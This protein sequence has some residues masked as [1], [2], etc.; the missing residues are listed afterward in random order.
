MKKKSILTIMKHSQAVTKITN[1]EKGVLLLHGF[2][3]SPFEMKHLGE[4]ISEQGYSIFI[5]RLPGHG[6]NIED[7]TLFNGRDWLNAAREALIEL[8]SHCREVCVI[9]LSMGGILSILLARTYPVKKIVLLSVPRAIKEKT[10]YLAPVIGLFKKILRREDTT[11]GLASE[12]ARRVHECY[13]SGIPLR[14]S[15]HLFRLIKKG[16]KALPDI[17]AETLLIQ[18]LNDRVIPRDSIDYIS[19]HAASAKKEK[20]LLK[21]SDH[22]ITAD[23]EKDAVAERV[24]EFLNRPDSTPGS[25]RCAHIFAEEGR[26]D[27]DRELERTGTRSGLG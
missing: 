10:I 7:M 8:R 9:G 1:P 11:M 26:S 18:S 2:K 4:K 23:L 17:E 15:W 27:P 24:I 16:M 5:P 19:S 13:S 12:E 25:R 22:A 20:F 6:T 14:Q 3:G 21:A